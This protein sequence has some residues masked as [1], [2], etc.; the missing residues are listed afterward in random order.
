MAIHVAQLADARL[1][2]L[3]LTSEVRKIPTPLRALSPLSLVNEAGSM[4]AW[5]DVQEKN[6]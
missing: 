1:H 2:E 4:P 6:F 3:A 5:M